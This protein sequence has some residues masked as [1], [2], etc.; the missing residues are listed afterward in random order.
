MTAE[1]DRLYRFDPLD[2]SGVFL[3]LGVIQCALVGGGLVLAV[4]A[5]TAGLP[6]L[7]AAL[8]ALA[9]VAVSFARVGGY[10]AWE[11]LPLG[12]SWILMRLGR[13]QRWH[14]RL[15]LLVGAGRERP[16][17][18][19]CLA[20]LDI[21]EI[22]WRGSLHLGAVRDRQ[23]HTL[24]AL[25]PASGPEFVTQPRAE[26][27][28]LLSGWGDVLSHFAAESSPVIHLGWSDLA[29]QSGMREHVAWLEGAERGERHAAAEESYRQLLEGAVT[30]ASAHEVVIFV[31]VAR[32]RL[33][34]RAL[35]GDPEAA[36]ARALASS[37][38]AL[39]RGLRTAGLAGA[40]PLSAADV[41]RVLRH[42]ID[43]FAA[44][45]R[46]T[47]GRLIERLGLVTSPGAG[48]MALE[49]DWRHA[50]IDGAWHRTYWI[51]GY[52]RLP[53]QPSWLEPFLAGPG[54]CRSITVFFRPV[55]TY[56][57][58]RRIERDL[59]KLESDAQTKE[60][61]GRRVDARHRRATQALL[62][63]EEELVAGF[64]EMGH[65][66]LVCVSAADLDQLENDCEVV[67]QLAREVGIELKVVDAL[68]DLAWACS[69]PFGL[70]VRHGLV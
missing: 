32:D 53:Q 67:E 22:P 27:E 36:L 41:R 46:V 69:L 61:K 63:R 56:Q 42:R 62:D 45:P 19:P 43:P 70:V 14:A 1:R 18:P 66:A 44:R 68:Q 40:D 4:T 33:G 2:R 55:S 48:P 24:T 39:L 47:N 29:R 37:V 21:I 54:V 51:V 50:R 12:A 5:I 17:L 65:N 8:P 35:A 9:G 57:S 13:G 6:L 58:R 31:T 10:A 3:G 60:D 25:V 20:G 38:E 34:R 15:P 52:P 59:V 30:Q 28:R 26:Q 7:V 64:P 16:P 11:W 23:Q 49:T